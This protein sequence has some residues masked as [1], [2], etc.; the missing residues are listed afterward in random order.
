MENQVSICE[1]EKGQITKTITHLNTSIKPIYP[2]AIVPAKT[3][4]EPGL[5]RTYGV[6]GQLINS[7]VKSAYGQTVATGF[8]KAI[9]DPI[10]DFGSSSS[11]APSPELIAEFTK[12]GYKINT[13]KDGT[14]QI[15]N[16]SLEIV[17][18][19]A[20]FR[21]IRK[22]FEN[23]RITHSVETKNTK[24]NGLVIPAYQLEKWYTISP[25]SNVCLIRNEFIKFTNY[26]ISGN[27]DSGKK[28]SRS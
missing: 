25:Q 27:T 4:I 23:G 2:Q 3:V 8:Q 9:Q 7:Y 22:E 26:N 6:N 10:S 13:Q 14:T 21:M 1:D 20:N 15:T 16:G 18:D 17:I 5:I 11:S 19:P 24:Q 12:L 28:K